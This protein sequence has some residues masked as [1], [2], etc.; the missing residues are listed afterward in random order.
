[1]GVSSRS[2]VRVFFRGTA[3]ESAAPTVIR[4]AVAMGTSR[5]PRAGPRAKEPTIN[6][7]IG[8]VPDELRRHDQLY[9]VKTLNVVQRCCPMSEIANPIS[10]PKLQSRRCLAC[11]LPPDL[12]EEIE[13]DRIRGWATFAQLVKKL[14]SKG[15]TLSDS[16][17]RRHFRHVPRDRYF[18]VGEGEDGGGEAVSTPLDGLLEGAI[19]EEAVCEALVRVLLER[20]QRLEEQQRGWRDHS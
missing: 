1:M 2:S 11:R 12:Q 4:I 10:A 6:V 8:D 18:E 9:L 15:F 13:R 3:P 5:P 14:S 7:N 20:P 16:A 17:V 19:S